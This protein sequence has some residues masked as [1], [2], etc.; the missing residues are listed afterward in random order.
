MTILTWPQL[1]FTMDVI[2]LKATNQ[3]NKFID[4]QN[5][6]LSLELKCSSD[7]CDCETLHI[8]SSDIFTNWKQWVLGPTKVEKYGSSV[9][10]MGPLP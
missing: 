3:T 8:Y 7:N 2:S 9:E 4:C 6:T 10:F 1:F 5:F